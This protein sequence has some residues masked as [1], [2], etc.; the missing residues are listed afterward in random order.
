MRNSIS[1]KNIL[2]ASFGSNLSESVMKYAIYFARLWK[3]NIDSLYVIPTTQ[4]NEKSEYHTEVE[5]Q[6]N[7][8]WTELSSRENLNKIKLLQKKIR[9]EN[10]KTSSNILRGVPCHEII[11]FAREKSAG[12]IFMDRG[13]KMGGKCIVQKTTQYVVNNATVPVLT[14]DSSNEFKDIKNILVPVYLNK[15][16]SLSFDF[17]LNLSKKTDNCILTILNINNPSLPPEVVERKHGDAYFNLSKSE[18]KHENINTAVVDN[19]SISG[20]IMDYMSSHEVDLI[21]LQTYLGNKKSVF[22]S[23]GSVAQDL[24]CMTECPL[25]TIRAD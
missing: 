9:N 4:D 5:K 19:E 22:H 13:I 21:V 18:M 1:M 11:N 14:S 17:A 15:V 2:W 6:L 24:L 7:E 16:N 12:M 25:V 3:I 10:I 23:E 20:G 8:E